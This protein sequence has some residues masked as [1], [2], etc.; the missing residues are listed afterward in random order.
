MILYI[1]ISLVTI[2]LRPDFH[3]FRHVQNEQRFAEAAEAT[4]L[5]ALEISFRM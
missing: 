4:A 1:Y 5:K 2:G 3:L